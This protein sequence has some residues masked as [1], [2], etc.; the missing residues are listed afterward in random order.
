MLYD[1][2]VVLLAAA[3]VVFL[4]KLVLGIL[5]VPVRGKGC[6]VCVAVSFEGDAPDLERVIRGAKWL[7]REGGVRLVLIDNGMDGHARKRAERFAAFEK[8]PLYTVDEIREN[9][10]HII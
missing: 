6:R 5:L 2:F 3:G 1:I 7:S 8:C 9:I 10:T 4:I